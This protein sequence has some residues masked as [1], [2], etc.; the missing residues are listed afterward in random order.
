M[1]LL[2]QLEELVGGVSSDTSL[3][4]TGSSGTIGRD[5]GPGPSG[6]LVGTAGGV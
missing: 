3:L 5:A 1:L 2:E 4:G 6:L